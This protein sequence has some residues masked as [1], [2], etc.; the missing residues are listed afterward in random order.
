MTS[1]LDKHH[2]ITSSQFGFTKGRTTEH[3]LLEQKEFI[4]D[5][6]ERELHTIGIFIDYS[7]AFD[8]INHVTLLQKCN[9]YGFRGVFL[10]LIESYLKYRQQVVV[11]NNHTS[12]LQAISAG[13]PQGSILGPL[14]FCIYIN[15]IVNIDASVKCVIYAD[16]T[17]LLLTAQHYKDLINDANQVLLKLANTSKTKAAYFR[18]RNKP[19]PLD[20]P[21]MLGTSELQ[22]VP[23]IK[24][25]GVI[26]D[27]HMS[28]NAHIE[29]LS[30]SVSRITG[31]LSRVRFL[32]PKKVKL[33]IYKSLFLSH[34]NYC[35][36]V[37]GTTTL[38]N[39]HKLHVIQKRA[40]RAIADVPYGS[41]TSPLFD[42]MNLLTLPDYYYTSLMKR[43]HTGL[44][45]DNFLGTL[46]RINQRTL[47]YNTRHV[48]TWFLPRTRTKYGKE[49]L[50]FLLPFYLNQMT[51]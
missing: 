38:T 42:E 3:A 17:T 2:I 18:P 9:H 45:S 31:I 27:E 8:T 21:L 37:W 39:I 23:R 35:H 20:A 29:K 5:A 44:K 10:K 36:L 22:I 16:D 40:V 19:S 26:F 47:L 41:H 25:L 4:L 30:S 12:N 50:R 32:L 1:F 51:I 11:I 15:D 34:I 14:L 7:K 33:L 49:M 46:A 48:H 6:F 13:V 28:W 24:C 43:Y